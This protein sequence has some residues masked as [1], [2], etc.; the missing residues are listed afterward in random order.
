MEECG[1]PPPPLLIKEQSRGSAAPR[2]QSGHR[3][4]RELGPAR[5]PNQQRPGFL[6]PP[7]ATCMRGTWRA[8]SIEGTGEAAAPHPVIVGCRRL[9]AHDPSP[10]K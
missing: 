10:P 2:D 4:H 9:E 1:M 8:S 7:P 5:C 3:G 6:P